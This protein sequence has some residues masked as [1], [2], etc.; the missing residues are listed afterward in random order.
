MIKIRANSVVPIEAQIKVFYNC[1]SGIKIEM[2]Q[3]RRFN[4]VA[5]FGCYN[6]GLT[7]KKVSNFY[8]DAILGGFFKIEIAVV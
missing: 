1:R 8:C 6:F 4:L 5:A 7:I 3:P 2:K